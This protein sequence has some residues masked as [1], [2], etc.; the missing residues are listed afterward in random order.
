MAAE[1]L[2]VEVAC[3]VLGVS[4]SGYYGWLDRPPSARAIR[5]VWLTELIT[6]IHADSRGS[7][8]A[9]RVHAELALGHGIA[10]GHEAVAMLMRR[11]GLQG[12]SGRPKYRRV[13]NLPTAS[14]LVDRRFHRDERDQLW[15]TD[16]TEHPT[17]EGKVYCAVVLDV[18]SRR[19]VGWSIDSSP[20]ATLVTNALGMA[21]DQRQPVAG[22][23]VIH[24]TRAP[25]S[26][27]GRSPS[28]PSI[29][30]CYRR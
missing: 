3:R 17:R 14:D 16:I 11:A 22:A 7:Y 10:V 6:K 15:V 21:I 26:H 13:P 20:T 12:L 28:E 24:R 29:R 5:H 18:F 2:P 4:V 23:T 9:R 27:R 19:V 8:G 25:N 1:G 30:G